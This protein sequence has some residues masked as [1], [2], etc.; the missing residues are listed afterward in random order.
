VKLVSASEKERANQ[1]G[2]VL[3]PCRAKDLKQEV[4]AVLLPEPRVG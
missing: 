1:V 3:W 2:Y 4:E